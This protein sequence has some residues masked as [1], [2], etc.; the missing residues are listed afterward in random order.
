LAEQNETLMGTT[1]VM[2]REE[3]RQLIQNNAPLQ[4]I[5]EHIDE[6]NMKLNQAE[7]LPTGSS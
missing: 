7:T 1:E 5:Q 3:L 2:L 4:E 6:I